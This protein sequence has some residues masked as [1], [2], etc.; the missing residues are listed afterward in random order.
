MAAK[1]K[2]EGS[3]EKD[4]TCHCEYQILSLENVEEDQNW[5]FK[6][7]SASGGV[8]GTGDFYLNGPNLT[9]LPTPFFDAGEE[10]CQKFLLLTSSG[11]SPLFTAAVRIRC[12]YAETGSGYEYVTQCVYGDGELCWQNIGR[13]FWRTLSCTHLLNGE[14]VD[15]KEEK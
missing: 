6:V 14:K 13:C 9:P 3:L 8:A 10:G 15:C 2:G 4:L 7:Y 5:F 11:Y 12:T 1:K